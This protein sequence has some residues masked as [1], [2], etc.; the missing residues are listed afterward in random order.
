MSP[1]TVESLELEH[2]HPDLHISWGSYSST[3]F[4][5]AT[6]RSYMLLKQDERTGQLVLGPREHACQ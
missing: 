4:Q 5:L 6:Y 1:V 3:H 2:L